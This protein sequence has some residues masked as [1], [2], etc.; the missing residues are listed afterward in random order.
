MKRLVLLSMVAMMLAATAFAPAAMAA[1]GDV[2]IQSV[3]QGTGGTAVVTGTIEC[4]QGWNYNVTA[5]VWQTTGN[6]PYNV[7]EGY[8]PPNGGWA[9][10][11]TTGQDTFTITVI[12]G[13]PFKN[14]DVLV[15]ESA[16]VCD[17]YFY[18]CQYQ[19]MSA[20]EEFR[21]H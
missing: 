2:Q 7:G 9:T 14:G 15:R 3:T 4:T 17:Q 1:T 12:G 18:T 11:S 6:K 21:I 20:F 8:Y 16:T 10:C 5:Q 13:K 19:P